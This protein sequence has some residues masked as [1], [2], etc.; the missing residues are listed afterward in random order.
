DVRDT[1]EALDLLSSRGA[2]GEAYNICSGNTVRIG[3]VVDLLLA[4]AGR[5][6][7]VQVEAARLRPFEE[8]IIWGDNRRLVACTGWS[9]KVSLK[10]TVV[11]TLGYWREHS[12]ESQVGV[13]RTFNAK[14]R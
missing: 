1:V 12:A 8:S 13:A 4:A 9:P 5:Q 10:Q 6:I 2:P 14:T 7:S 11:D 3:D